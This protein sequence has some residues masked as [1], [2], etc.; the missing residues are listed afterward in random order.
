VDTVQKILRVE[1][2]PP[3]GSEFAINF[4]FHVFVLFLALT[5]LFKFVIAPLESETVTRELS[6]ACT[7]GVKAGFA[8][9][10]AE[11]AAQEPVIRER[12]TSTLR[13]AIPFLERLSESY[14]EPDP[15]V[16]EHNSRVMNYAYFT[17]AILAIVLIVFVSVLK[18]SGISVK[19]PI[20]QVLFE[21][22]I[23]FAIVGAAEY[24]FFVL[25]ASKYVPIMPSALAA[26]VVDTL[27]VQFPVL[28]PAS[29]P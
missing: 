29:A 23:V 26:T 6:V 24:S 20:L 16:V 27:K 10:S 2:Q 3:G 11:L 18:G 9:F 4:L 14:S 1:V 19:K 7:D 21:N 25:V 17:L 13:S 22:L 28:P 12:A 8:S 15:A 5:A